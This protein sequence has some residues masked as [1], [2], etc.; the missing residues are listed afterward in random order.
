LQAAPSQGIPVRLE[1][2]LSTFVADDRDA[3]PFAGP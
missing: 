3:Q 1:A 2:L